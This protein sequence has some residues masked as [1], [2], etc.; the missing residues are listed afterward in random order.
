MYGD[1]NDIITFD[2]EWPWKVKFKV[3]QGQMWLCRCNHQ[4]WFAIDIY[5]NH[6]SNSHHLALIATQNVFSY[7]LSLGLNYEILQV[8]RMTSKWPRRLKDQRYALC[9]VERTHESQISLR[10]ALRSLVFQIIEVFDFSIGYNGEFEIFEK[11]SL[12]II[13][14]T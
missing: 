8:H 12:I 5:S 4:L 3:T 14:L 9:V 2:L 10:F 11:K 6:R 1:S 13:L 7:L